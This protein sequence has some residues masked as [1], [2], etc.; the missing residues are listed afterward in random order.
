MSAI[1]RCGQIRRSVSRTIRMPLVVRQQNA[2]LPG[3]LGATLTTLISLAQH[4]GCRDSLL[5]VRPAVKPAVTLHLA[6]TRRACHTPV[7]FLYERNIEI[8]RSPP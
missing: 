4:F 8:M 1:L 6:R 5:F 2:S 3:S 7:T